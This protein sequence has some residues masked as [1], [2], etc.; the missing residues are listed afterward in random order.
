MKKVEAFVLGNTESQKRLFEEEALLKD[1]QLRENMAQ[2]LKTENE[3]SVENQD[4]LTTVFYRSRDFH[5][6][7]SLTV[8]N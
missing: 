2:K 5:T 7:A 6:T 1:L 4:D 8:Q 3:L